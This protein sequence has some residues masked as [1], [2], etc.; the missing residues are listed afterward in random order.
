PAGLSTLVIQQLKSDLTGLQSQRTQLAERLGDR[1]P[2]M[3]KVQS[4]IRSAET[5]LQNEI[6]KVVQ[7]VRNEYLAAQAQE[8]S[9]VAELEAQKNEALALDRKAIDYR[10]LQRDAA[11]NR[12]V[13]ESLLQRAKEMGISEEL[14]TS[15]IRIVDQ[16]EVP[17]IPVSP[18]N[19]LNLALG[20]L[21]GSALA[22]GL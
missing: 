9:L 10:A 5:K 13:F 7:S 19:L 22:H 3:V 21:G 18:Q 8:R 16:A 11:T 4:S 12:Q 14:R 6:A 20:M 15:N 17:R 1:H 2:E